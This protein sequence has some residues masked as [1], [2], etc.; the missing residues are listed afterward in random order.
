MT[1]FDSSRGVNLPACE[2]DVGYVFQDYAL[3]PHLSVA[4]NVAFGLRAQGQSRGQ[5]LQARM[6]ILER[7]GIAALA[8]AR[9]SALSGGQQQ[10]VALARALVLQPKLLLLDE[11][12]A[13]LDLQ[14]RARFA[15]S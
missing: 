5:S 13:A 11:P 8:T 1:Y 15:P 3:F 12:L 10:R 7:L 2:R 4:D 6:E 9:P 14:T